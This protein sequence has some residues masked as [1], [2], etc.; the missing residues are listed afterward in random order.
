MKRKLIIGGVVVALIAGSFLYF[1][2]KKEDIIVVMDTG[3]NYKHKDLEKYILKDGGKVVG[4]DFYNNDS[5]PMDDN[6]HGT[7]CAGII[8]NEL[9]K[10]GIK[11]FKIMPIKIMD[12]NG[13]GGVQP[14]IKAY[15]YILKKKMKDIML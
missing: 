13:S 15:Q 14:I 5:N 12:E 4:Y 7:H 3:V 8:V 2:R 10:N 9:T 1:N 6:G 11:D